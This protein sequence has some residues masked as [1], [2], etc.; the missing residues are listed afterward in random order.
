MQESSRLSLAFTRAGSSVV[1][2]Y[3]SLTPFTASSTSL[4]P[5]EIPSGNRADGM[6]IVPSSF[7]APAQRSATAT[8]FFKASG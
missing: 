3:F 5:A 8:V 1:F 2:R 4:R 6:C 7:T